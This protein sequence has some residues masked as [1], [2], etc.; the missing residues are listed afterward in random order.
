[1]NNKRWTDDEKAAL[2]TLWA[3]GKTVSVIAR[4]MGKSE[5]GVKNQRA[6]LG[7]PKRRTGGLKV[8]VR[9]GIHTDEHALFR[10][11]AKRKNQTVPGRIRDLIQ[12][13]LKQP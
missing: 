8:K 4:A 11:K 12:E 13:D 1:M 3:E 6:A 10:E 2:R 9:V 7:L 5:T